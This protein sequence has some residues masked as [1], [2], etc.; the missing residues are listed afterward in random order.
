MH[1]L[2]NYNLKETELWDDPEQDGSDTRR[3]HEERKELVKRNSVALVR[4]RT[5]PTEL[6]PFVAKVSANFCG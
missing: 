2:W 6:P 1:R 4:E 5:I 3:I